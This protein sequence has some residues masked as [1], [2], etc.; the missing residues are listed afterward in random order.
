MMLLIY[1]GGFESRQLHH[2]DT[3]QTPPITGSVD[4]A[5]PT[6]PLEFTT[7]SHE[8]HTQNHSVAFVRLFQLPKTQ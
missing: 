7:K 3:T 8:N 4:G 1:G 5:P 2:L 6:N